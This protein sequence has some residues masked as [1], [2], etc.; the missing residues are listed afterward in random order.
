[1]CPANAAIRFGNV[2]SPALLY[3]RIVQPPSCC[4]RN[5]LK[6]AQK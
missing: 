3:P 6:L 4:V 1:L 2:F 5:W